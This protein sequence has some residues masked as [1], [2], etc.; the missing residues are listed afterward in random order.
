[1]KH[2]NHILPGDFAWLCVCDGTHFLVGLDNGEGVG[3]WSFK[4]CRQK[5]PTQKRFIAC[6]CVLKYR[7]FC[8]CSNGA[9]HAPCPPN[10]PHP[11]SNTLDIT[12]SAFKIIAV[13]K[14]CGRLI[15]VIFNLFGLLQVDN[16]KLDATKNIYNAGD[17]CITAS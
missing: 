10:T 17:Q 7:I 2:R 9:A 4:T 14:E 3:G 13:E 11:D 5:N 15:M 12:H 8:T 6:I 1:M 16:M